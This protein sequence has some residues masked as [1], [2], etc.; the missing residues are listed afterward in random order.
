MAL[1]NTL[2]N[3]F[4]NADRVLRLEIR[5]DTKQVKRNRHGG[6]FDVEQHCAIERPALHYDI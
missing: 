3:P 6:T 2:R 4:S 1:W 5:R